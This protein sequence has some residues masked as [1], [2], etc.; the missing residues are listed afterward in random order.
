MYLVYDLCAATSRGYHGKHAESSDGLAAGKFLSRAVVS[1][2]RHHGRR[3]CRTG[4]GE[5]GPEFDAAAG[6]G[7]ADAGSGNQ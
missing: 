1:A 7:S 6:A 4:M 3:S 2:P 5:S